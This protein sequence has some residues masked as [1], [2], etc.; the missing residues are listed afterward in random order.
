MNAPFGHKLKDT[1]ALG[2]AMILDALANLERPARAFLRGA[3]FLA[4]PNPASRIAFARDEAG[5]PIAAFPLRRKSVGPPQLG[6]TVKQIAGPYWPMRG[7]PVK[8]DT[9]VE[10]LARALRDKALG[11]ALGPA[12]RLGPAL[13]D[14]PSLQLLCKAAE[15]A[16]WCVLA[17]PVGELFALDLAALTASGTWPSSKGRQKDRWRVRQLEKTGPVSIERFT[18][19]DWTLSTR[20]AIAAIEAH[21]WVGQLEE[22]GDTKFMDPDL[23]A[24]WEDIATD[25]AFAEMIRGS[26]LRVGDTPAAFTFGLDSGTTRYCIANNFDQ[27]FAKYSPGRILLYDDF[28]SAAERGIEWLDWGPGDAGYKQQM[29]AKPAGA[30]VDLLFVRS[31][32][33]ARALRPLWER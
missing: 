32:L 1:G 20:D 21:S 31:P 16:G 19:A 2:D 6:I 5:Q 33:L 17:K 9:P 14:D 27:R 11:K 8:A 10:T 7:V 24:T 22:G 29:G 3:W 12:F 18:G 28:T 26:I 30:F 13:Q 4:G 25:A 15:R 23:R